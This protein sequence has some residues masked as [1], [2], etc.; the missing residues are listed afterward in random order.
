MSNNLQVGFRLASADAN[1]ANA[2]G[3]APLSNNSNLQG[4][5]TKKFLYI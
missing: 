4:N 1:G 2:L 5:G 3:G